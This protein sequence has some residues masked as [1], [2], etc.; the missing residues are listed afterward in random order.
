MESLDENKEEEEEEEEPPAVEE[1]APAPP[2]PSQQQPSRLV[3]AFSLI[4]RNKYPLWSLANEHWILMKG[5][6]GKISW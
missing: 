5:A 1:P 6:K 3:M 2:V 4:F